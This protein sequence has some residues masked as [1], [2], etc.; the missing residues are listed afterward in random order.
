[1]ARQAELARKTKETDIALKLN[2]DGVGESKLATGVGFF[3]HMLTHLA[4]HSGW[5]LDVR[6]KGDLEVD[7]HHT[8]EDI[9]ICIGQ[10]IRQALGDKAGIKRFASALVPM[11]EALAEV[12]IDIS[13]RAYLVYNAS[14]P[15]EKIGE[16]DV[17]LVEEF[18]RAV[19]HNAGVTL[20]VNAR[21][22]GNSHH[23]AEGIFKAVAQAFGA[24]TR[25]T[26]SSAIPSTKGSL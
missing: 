2:L 1:M 19:V 24:A 8:V 13:G 18:L 3:D 17:E 23:I 12:A 25:L 14:Y 16:F 7:A 9:G 20:H 22:G 26:G 11:D 10:A 4:K 5:D 6:A 15:S 21:Y